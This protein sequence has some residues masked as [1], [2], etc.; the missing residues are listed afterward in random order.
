MLIKSKN[1]K[2]HKKHVNV[3]PPMFVNI[4]KTAMFLEHNYAQQF[5]KH[6]W[7]GSIQN[8]T[9]KQWNTCSYYV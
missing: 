7:N 9:K 4:D 1:I 5:L 8:H 3:F 2:S 6:E